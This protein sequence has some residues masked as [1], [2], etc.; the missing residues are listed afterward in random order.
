MRKQNFISLIAVL[1]RD[2]NPTLS[3][4][5]FP[6]VLAVLIR[7]VSPRLPNIAFNTVSRSPP[8]A[9]WTQCIK[10]ISR[11]AYPANRRPTAAA[12]AGNFWLMSLNRFMPRPS[13]LSAVA[14][15]GGG[16]GSRIGSD[17]S[18]ARIAFSVMI[19]GDNGDD[20]VKLSFESGGRED[21]AATPGGWE[22]FRIEPPPPPVPSRKT[23]LHR[24]IPEP[25]DAEDRSIYSSLWF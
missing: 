10:L 9:I 8:L 23:E 11:S 15:I 14:V 12:S 16:G 22:P 25:T 5:G 3:Y 18:L 1:N 7:C 21:F 13:K 24:K 2:P 20:P 19:R 4:A 6:S 17:L